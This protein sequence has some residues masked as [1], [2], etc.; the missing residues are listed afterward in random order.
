VSPFE[1]LIP[2]FGI[3]TALV[4]ITGVTLI[5]AARYAL[6]PILRELAASRQAD[7]GANVMLGAQLLQMSEEIETLRAEVHRLKEVNDFDR[8][9]LDGGSREVQL[10]TGGR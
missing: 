7:S 5:L 6:K 2:I 4:P 9:L 1:V 8:R 3:L 10:Q